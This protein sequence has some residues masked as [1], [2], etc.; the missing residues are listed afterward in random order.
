MDPPSGIE[1]PA[2]A[3]SAPRAMDG[4]AL[5]SAHGSVMANPPV[6]HPA[7]CRTP[8]PAPRSKPPTPP[9]LI[10]TDPIERSLTLPPGRPGRASRPGMPGLAR[11]LAHPSFERPTA[12]MTHITAPSRSPLTATPPTTSRSA[13]IDTSTRAGLTVA[14]A[15]HPAYLS[16][17]AADPRQ[18]ACVS[19]PAPARQ[20]TQA[21]YQPCQGDHQQRHRRRPLEERRRAPRKHPRPHASQA[22]TANNGTMRAGRP[23]CQGPS[24]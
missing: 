12:S 11:P 18:P 14:V 22:C 10:E 9:G 17:H 4:A 21:G 13:R 1:P 19:A 8:L 2:P 7:I 6:T 3:A 15:D 5:T 24:Y 16:P 20:A 23:G